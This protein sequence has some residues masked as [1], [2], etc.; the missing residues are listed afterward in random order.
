MELSAQ[1]YTDTPFPS[2]R[3]VPG[4]NPHPI[5]HPAG[6][7]YVPPGTPEPHMELRAPEKWRESRE[8]LYGCDL[9]NHGY[10]WEAHEAWEHLWR[11]TDRDGVQFEFLKA[12]IQVSACHLKAY[13]GRIAGVRR[14]QA[15]SLAH[16]R[17]VI[18]H[19]EGREFMG[20]NVTRWYIEVSEYYARLIGSSGTDAHEYAGYP[21]IVLVGL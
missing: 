14:L 10:W 12:L 8:Y 16:L 17:A 15:S 1:R 5:A 20:L 6:H 2:Y 21:Y 18:E 3:F 11:L 13:M 19:I 7:S 9:Y 4:R